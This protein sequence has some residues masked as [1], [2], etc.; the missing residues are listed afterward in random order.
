[1]GARRRAAGAV[2]SVF[3]P[4]CL[5]LMMIVGQR[6]GA[7]IHVA[8]H[9]SCKRWQDL[10][11]SSGAGASGGGGGVFWKCMSCKKCVGQFWMPLL[12]AHI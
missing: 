10:L 5:V 11:F 7:C 9:G 8:P 1:M 4:V 6:Y 12:L 3:G 2:E